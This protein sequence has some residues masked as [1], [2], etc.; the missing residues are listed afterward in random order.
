MAKKKKF[1]NS[2]K[3]RSKKE[4]LKEKK[5]NPFEYKITKAKRDTLNTKVRKHQISRPGM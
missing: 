5:I 1:L 2:E 4:K 3:I